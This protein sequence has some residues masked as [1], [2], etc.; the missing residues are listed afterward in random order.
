MWGQESDSRSE[1]HGAVFSTTHWSVV[2]AAGR[3]DSPQAREALEQLCRT[4][5]YPLYAHVRRCGYSHEDAQDLTQGFFLQLLEHDYCARANPNRGRFRSFLLAGLNRYLADQHDRATARKRGA[6]QAV[7]SF[8]AQTADARYRLEP[9]DQQSPDKL[10]ER[11]W[12]QTMLAQVLAHL[13]RE[14]QEAGKAEL[15]RRLRLFLVA[16]RDEGSYAQAATDLGLTTD[17]VRKAAQR[18]R[19]R[20][21]KL[22]REEIAHTVADAVEVE[23]EMRHLCAVMAG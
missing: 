19:Q 7:L 2:L 11:R 6:G 12:A 14:F 16:G 4:Y 18:L 1:A 22:F 5:W 9:L 10:F 20:Y 15:F 3:S 8:D 13:G 17:A 21:Y 23:D